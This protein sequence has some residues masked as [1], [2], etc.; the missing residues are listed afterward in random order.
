MLKIILGNAIQFLLVCILFLGLSAC[1]GGG[2]GG[3]S[4]GSGGAPSSTQTGDSTTQHIP[5]FPQDPPAMPIAQ[6][7]GSTAQ[8]TPS[9][10]NA[11]SVVFDALN[12]LDIHNFLAS[13]LISLPTPADPVY[14][15]INGASGGTKTVEG[16]L[17]KN[18]TGW[19]TAEYVNYKVGQ[20]TEDGL[21]ILKITSYDKSTLKYDATVGYSSMEF[22]YPGSDLIF[23]GVVQMTGVSIIPPIQVSVDNISTNLTASNLISNNTLYLDDVSLSYTYCYSTRYCGTPVPV[24][25]NISGS[26]YESN[27]GE[28]GFTS[29]DKVILSMYSPSTI[30]LFSGSLKM[31][32][33]GDEAVI[34]DVLNP[35]LASIGLDLTGSGTIQEAARF[36]LETSTVDAISDPLGRKNP[37]AAINQPA[38]AHIDQPVNLDAFYSHSPKGVFLSYQWNLKLVPPGSAIKTGT[39]NGGVLSFIPDLPGDYLAILTVSD[40]EKTATDAYVV[41]VYRAD[42]P[43]DPSNYSA[44]ALGGD[45]AANIG[46]KV[47]LDGRDAGVIPA[48][49]TFSWSLSVPTGSKTTLVNPTSE[50]PYFIPDVPGYYAVEDVTSEYP[51]SEFIVGVGVTPN[52]TPPVLLDASVNDNDIIPSG[53]AAIGDINHDN[54]P[55]YLYPYGDFGSA[56]G[57]VVV[58][59]QNS[60][61][62][63][64]Q[65]LVSIG[66][67]TSQVSFA[68]LNN[69]GFKDVVAAGFNELSYHVLFN[70]LDG[71]LDAPLLISNGGI[72]FSTS[73]IGTGVSEDFISFENQPVGP[74]AD[75]GL[76]IYTYSSASGFVPSFASYGFITDFI[77]VF[78]ITMADVTGD[79]VPDVV[80]IG[81][82]SSS[83]ESII[84]MPG[85]SDGTFGS[86]ITYPFTSDKLVSSNIAVGDINNDRLN[87]IVAISRENA[88][89]INIFYQKSDG[90]L[91]PAVSATLP[92]ASVPGPYPYIGDINADGRNDLLEYLNDSS[93]AQFFVGMSFQTTSGNLSS[94][95]LYPFQSSAF[96]F[97]SLHVQILIHDMDGDGLPDMILDSGSSGQG[98]YIMY[99]IPFN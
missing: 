59:Q 87:D 61:G 1:G 69:D 72:G 49:G 9:S 76:N 51:N 34:F 48:K 53:D 10:S 46:Q 2:G 57:G 91:N 36:D 43:I 47:Q 65:N 30:G 22:K 86:P 70:H 24:Y 52:F 99:Q 25:D 66:T 77:D 84:V 35:Q 33:A 13:T 6:Y 17:A 37:V 31:L 29:P 98:N 39:S 16:R 73:A 58:L 55:D 71:T 8:M 81:T 75:V 27:L 7:S 94:T 12:S 78:P 5:P 11:Q 21:V 79:G 95:Y 85:L 3:S 83:P 96:I 97:D 40:G 19:I 89:K 38:F 32:G 14:E 23:N 67:P 42:E 82:Y 28:F 74:D 80:A 44:V 62:S 26:V 54:H 90:T 4:I 20:F 15:V 41:H 63:F 60:D 18:G 92:I 68:D 56:D 64:S 50:F 88:K 45:V 93:T